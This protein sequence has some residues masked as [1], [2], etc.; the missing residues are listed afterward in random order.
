MTIEKQL[1][2]KTLYK[3]YVQEQDVQHPMKV[4]GEHFLREKMNEEQS[5]ISQIRFAQGEVYFHNNDY[6]AAIFK[7]EKVKSDFTP[8]AKKNIGDSYLELSAYSKAEDIYK[9]VK[10]ENLTLTTEIDL[11]LFSLYLLTNKIELAFK[12]IKKVVEVNPDYPLVIEKAHSFFEEQE[13]CYSA[14]ELAVNESIRTEDLKWF[15]ILIDYIHQGY[16]KDF[17]PDYFMEVL[18]TL[19]R[20]DIDS[21]NTTILGL[22]DEYRN[23]PSYLTWISVINDLFNSI[24]GVPKGALIVISEEYYETYQELVGG[25]FLLSDLKEIMP[26]YLSNWLKIAVRMNSLIPSSAILAWSENFPDSIHEDVVSEAKTRICEIGDFSTGLKESYGLLYDVINWSEENDVPL[27]SKTKWVVRELSNLGIQHLLVAGKSG[28]GKTSFINTILGENVLSSPTSTFIF[29]KDNEKVEINEITEDA[30]SSIETDPELIDKDIMNQER[31]E[32]GALVEFTIPSAFLHENRLAIIDTPGFKGT[33]QDKIE[34]V[35]YVHLA[36]S[37]LFVL[38]P[39]KPFSASERELLLEIEEFVPGMPIHFLLTKMDMIY[40]ESEAL[41]MI[42]HTSAIIHEYFPNSM[43]FPYSIYESHSKQDEIKN[44]IKSHLLNER[45]EDVRTKKILLFTRKTIRTL[46]VKRMEMEDELQ[47]FINWNESIVAKIRATIYQL[48]DV[49]KEK[50]DNIIQRYTMIKEEIKDNLSQTIPDLL[51]GCSGLIT[52]GSDFSTIHIELNEE[53]NRRIY[54][55]MEKDIL[56]NYLS[57]LQEWIEYSRLQFEESKTYLEDLKE[58]F[59]ALYKEERIVFEYDFKILEDWNRDTGRMINQFRID[60]EN[61]LLQFTPSQ[62]L[63]KSASKLFTALSTNN[64]MLLKHYKKYVENEEYM[65]VTDTV[66][67]KFLKQFEW[68]E[69]SLERDIAMFFKKTYTVLDETIDMTEE[70]IKESKNILYYSKENP[71][72]FNDPLT[73]FEIQ[74]RQYELIMNV[75]QHQTPYPNR[76]PTA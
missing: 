70:E 72:L 47:E 61:I 35:D 3:T 65:D 71:E 14:V 5:D 25:G 62:L 67:R 27:G 7:W 49:E 32:R 36:D 43:V 42:E 33:F 44:S 46:L 23:Q 57:S 60:E 37:L 21:F 69:K 34:L 26:A 53:M 6:E 18:K 40:S 68:F 2:E 11:Q 1:I 8:W 30:I 31:K 59:N 17:Q 56:P 19:Y 73:L 15:T 45:L 63:L 50:S 39:N 9:S 64:T 74:L 58:S 16:A 4:L 52:E 76:L 51:Q 22:W 55:Y 13:D 10:T 41:K 12:I 38:N 54:E 29:V 75:K 24:D 20:T 48:N 28:S 66:T